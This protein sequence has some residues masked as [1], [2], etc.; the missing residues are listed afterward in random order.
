[1][2]ERLNNL[3]LKL[4]ERFELLVSKG[5]INN[6]K[7]SSFLTKEET[8]FNKK[9]GHNK[10]SQP[11]FPILLSYQDSQKALGV[12]LMAP[13]TPIPEIDIDAGSIFNKPEFN[14]G[15]A[16]FNGFSVLRIDVEFSEK[17]N[18]LRPERY[19][20]YKENVMIGSEFKQSFRPGYYLISRENSFINLPVN[21]EDEIIPANI[22]RIYPGLLLEFVIVLERLG[23]TF[24]EDVYYRTDAIDGHGKHFCIG[25]RGEAFHLKQFNGGKQQKIIQSF[26]IGQ[27]K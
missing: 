18:F 9:K 27:G 25:K 22:Q 6:E 21:K 17:I 23:A 3:S 16:W 26:L 2:S 24:P 14:W 8:R 20:W 13:E 5:V 10:K 12:Y 11:I 4:R 1:M 15:W 7:L 19:P